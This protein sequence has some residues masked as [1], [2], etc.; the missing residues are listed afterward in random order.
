[1][2]HRIFEY[3]MNVEA[4]SFSHINLFIDNILTC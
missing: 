3:F 2:K 1:M 4:P